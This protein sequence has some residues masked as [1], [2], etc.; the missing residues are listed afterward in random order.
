MNS[1]V[2]LRLA[3]RQVRRAWPTSL[4]IIALVTLPIVLIAGSA[5]FFSSR[6]PSTVQKITAELG[7]TD[8]WF[9]IVGGPDPSRSQAVDSP[10]NFEI[11]YGLDGDPV[12]PELPEPDEVSGIPTGTPV[13]TVAH[14]EVTAKTPGGTGLLDA[15]VGDAADPLL[16]G[17]YELLE[18]RR[19][20]SDNE[21][22]VS[23]GALA[24]LDAQVDDTLTLTAP[25]TTLT[26]VGVMKKAT[27]A[28]G[29]QSVFVTASA[30]PDVAIDPLRTFWFTPDWQPSADEITAMN[31]AGVVAY[32]RDL[33]SPSGAQDYVDPSTASTIT[34]ATLIVGSFSAY[35]VILLAGAGFAVSAR[36]QQRSLAVAASVGADRGSVFRIV[37]LQGS[38]LGL[39]GGVLGSIIG[40]ALAYPALQILDDGAA[41][42]FWGFHIPWPGIIGVVA[43]A[44]AVGTASAL[45]PARAATRGDVLSSLRDARKPV[46]VRVDR[47]FWGTLIILA[48][49]SLTIAGGL[50]LAAMNAADEIAYND[51]MR[52]VCMIGIVA[53]PILF[54][55]GTIMAG[56]WLLSLIARAATPLGLAP[57]IAA[58][59]AAANPSRVVPAFAAIAACVFIASFAM[60]AVGVFNG[61]QARNWSFQAPLGSVY[62]NI[63]AYSDGGSTATQALDALRATD[64]DAIGVVYN[65]TNRVTDGVDT[66]FISTETF[67]YADCDEIESGTCTTKRD[68]AIGSTTP[69]VVAPEDLDTVLGTV[70]PDNVRTRFADGGALALD[71][72]RVDAG[73]VVMH[74]WDPADLDYGEWT[75]STPLPD[76]LDTARIPAETINTPQELPW[77]VILSPAAADEFG[78]VTSPS[79]AIGSFTT[80]PS[81]PILDQLNLSATQSSDAGGAFNADIENGPPE[82]TPWLWLIIGAAG[83]LVLGAGGV[84]LGLARIERRPDDATLAA[85]GA[86]PGIRRRIAFW[87]ALI[88][89]GIGSV[90]G[91]IAGVIPTWGIT[92]VTSTNDMWATHFTDVPVL[93]LIGLASTLPLL[94]AAASWLIPP[95]APDLTRRTVIA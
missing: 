62:V 65:D 58:R 19:P 61:T 81:Q 67:E 36:R 93:W 75:E 91:T 39:V 92:M 1:R 2:E 26:I 42:S 88:I 80:P 53:G 14:A 20:T 40:I 38:V 70:V 66:D 85:V 55:I 95:R 30:L 74:R 5:V 44:V 17:R 45:M 3:Q 57:R 27:D 9:T 68:A 47:P 64:P 6:I 31:H 52:V 41:S 34:M 24:R 71:S 4:L 86:G 37:L 69:V 8:A 43:F 11:E 90:T 7:Q 94:I 21:A 23:P 82:S 63:W 48:G 50:G 73:D 22:L 79:V 49:V 18:G 25:K 60:S 59:D 35:L 33:V 87:Q 84:A 77:P 28:D 46:A 83:T 51:P 10:Y 72:A 78:Y 15:W 56:H 76:P 29:V 89:V 32:A 12:N 16:N 13:L 54:Q